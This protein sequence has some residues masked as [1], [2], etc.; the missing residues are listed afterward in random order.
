M[1][2]GM[3]SA[4]QLMRRVSKKMREQ[5]KGRSIIGNEG[6]DVEESIRGNEGTEE[7]EGYQWE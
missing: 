1:W 5:K 4:L 3:T 7:E 6:T 2:M